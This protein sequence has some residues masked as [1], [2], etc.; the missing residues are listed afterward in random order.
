[1]KVN[2]AVGI[3]SADMTQAKERVEQALQEWFTGQRLVE[4]VLR[5]KLGSIIFAVDGVENYTLSQ[6]AADMA[7]E[8]GLLPV[9][10]T[11]TVE[12]MT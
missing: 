1:M 10:G 5:A 2:I 6:P 7:I 3:K 11:V 4:D 12:E 9:L 8:K